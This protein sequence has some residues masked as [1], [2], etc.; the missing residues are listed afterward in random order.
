MS[1]RGGWIGDERE[2]ET[3]DIYGTQAGG[4]KME[5]E[6]NTQAGVLFDTEADSD[7]ISQGKEY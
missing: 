4:E 1:G 5:V 6:R 7:Q 3:R 2:G